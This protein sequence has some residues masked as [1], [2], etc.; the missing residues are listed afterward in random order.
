MRIHPLKVPVVLRD[1]SAVW[2][3]ILAIMRRIWM[4]VLGRDKFTLKFR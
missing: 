1:S 2:W 4:G 3:R